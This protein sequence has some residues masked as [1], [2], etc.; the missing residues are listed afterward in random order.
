M[1]LGFTSP[2]DGRTYPFS[3]MEALADVMPVP[4]LRAMM[5][6]EA[7]DH[8]HQGDHVTI[9]MGLGCPRKALI[10]RMLYVYPD[11]TKMWKMFRG[12]WLHEQI[13]MALG[14]D[15]EWWTEETAPDKCVFEGELFGL[16][17]SCKVDAL[18]RDFSELWDWKFRGDGSEKF[19]DEFGT[20][21]EEDAAQ[22]NM[23][24][25]LIEQATGRDLSDMKMHVWVM[26]GQTCKTT[27]PFMSLDQIGAIKPG[28]GI[29]TVQEL[30]KM[31]NTSMYKWRIKAGENGGDL[32]RVAEAD[33]AHIIGSLP[34]VGEHMFVKRDW[35]TKKPVK[36][37]NGCTLYCEVQEACMGVGV[38]YGEEGQAD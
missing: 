27:A 23:A 21:K 16:R 26:A 22:V 18:K 35:R 32:K 36:E 20:A 31:I 17:M 6:K 9:T 14:E 38:R 28:G 1:I 30:F 3:E 15:Q 33:A 34:L 24:R 7:E 13:G 8:R 4:V 12:T 19:V 37:L 29:Y 5:R 11:P 10:H 25:M 2:R